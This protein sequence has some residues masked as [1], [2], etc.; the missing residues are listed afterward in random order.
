M[1]PFDLYYIEIIVIDVSLAKQSFSM[2]PCY[3]NHLEF[4]LIQ[5]SGPIIIHHRS[6]HLRPS[7]MLPLSYMV[8]IIITSNKFEDTIIS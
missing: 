2:L 4:L 6:L 3:Q 1:I 5:I 8:F 7:H